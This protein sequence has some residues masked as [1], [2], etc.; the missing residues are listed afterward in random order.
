MA[1][2]QLAWRI[3]LILVA[4][5]TCEKLRRI[6]QSQGFRRARGVAQHLMRYSQDSPAFRYMRRVIQRERSLGA[7]SQR[8]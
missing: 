4:D 3:I 8:C 5:A 7:L 2:R 1:S 6:Q